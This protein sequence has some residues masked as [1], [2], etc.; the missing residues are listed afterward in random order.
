MNIDDISKSLEQIVS[1]DGILDFRKQKLPFE[2]KEYI[3]EQRF[4]LTEVDAL[5]SREVGNEQF[6]KI[7]K[8][9]LALAASLLIKIKADEDNLYFNGEPILQWNDKHHI[10]N[11]VLYYKSKS[12]YIFAFVKDGTSSFIQYSHKEGQG[13]ILYSDIDTFVLE[14]TKARTQVIVDYLSTIWADTLWE[15]SY[16]GTLSIDKTTPVAKAKTQFLATKK[17]LFIGDSKKLELMWSDYFVYHVDQNAI[18]FIPR[19][20]YTRFF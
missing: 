17:G 5:L 14:L 13:R 2:I 8:N 3:T 15:K 18:F 16:P 4:W 1:N 6:D 20:F 7:P 10:E 9:K 19:Q 11:N 12:D